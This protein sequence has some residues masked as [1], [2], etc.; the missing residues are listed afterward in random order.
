MNDEPGELEMTTENLND[1]DM[2]KIAAGNPGN[3]SDHQVD[4]S[5]TKQKLAASDQQLISGGGAPSQST[6]NL[7]KPGQAGAP[8][9]HQ[10]PR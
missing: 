3:P 6:A 7:S 8:I 5:Q 2:E 9:D 10:A 4:N 1:K